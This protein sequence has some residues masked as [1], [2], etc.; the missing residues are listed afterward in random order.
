VIVSPHGWLWHRRCTE[1]Q[2]D[3]FKSKAGDPLDKPGKGSVVGQLG[4]EGSGIGARGDL[5]VVEL[6]AERSVCPAGKSDLVGAW[7]HWVTPRS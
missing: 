7:W 1:A 3:D 4:A 5:A 2:A 6:C